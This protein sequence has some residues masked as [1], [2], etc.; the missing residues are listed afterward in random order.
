MSPSPSCR[1]KFPEIARTRTYTV[2]F[3]QGYSFNTSLAVD[4]AGASAKLTNLGYGSLNGTDLFFDIPGDTQYFG[5]ASGSLSDALS[6]TQFLNIWGGIAGTF[7]GPVI[8]ATM[9]GEINYWG[10]GSDLIGGPT[11][12][13]SATDHV[14]TLQR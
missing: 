3:S 9:T 2:R 11:V 14:I 5:W 7:S 10:P 4:I 8:H 1:D 13:C 6:A 12:V